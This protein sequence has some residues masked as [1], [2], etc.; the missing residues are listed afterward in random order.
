M[1]TPQE[2]MV[3]DQVTVICR[4]CGDQRVEVFNP[5]LVGAQQFITYT[6]TKL[7][8]CPCGHGFCDLKARLAK[9]PSEPSVN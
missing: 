5:H 3:F 9:D 7:F 1:N 6:K 8:A 2:L 4:G